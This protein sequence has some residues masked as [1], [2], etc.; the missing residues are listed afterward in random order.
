MPKPLKNPSGYLN[1]WKMRS[2]TAGTN[3]LTRIRLRMSCQHQLTTIRLT[4]VI[5]ITKTIMMTQQIPIIV[6]SKRLK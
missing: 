1:A 5:K 2:G 3:L 4:K 6:N